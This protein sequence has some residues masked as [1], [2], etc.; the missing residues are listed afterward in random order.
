MR[1]RRVDLSLTVCCV[2]EGIVAGELRKGRSCWNGL[3]W[4]TG[5]NVVVSGT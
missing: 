4:G 1:R 3:P 5:G 2:V